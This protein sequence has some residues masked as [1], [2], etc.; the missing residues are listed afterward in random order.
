MNSFQFGNPQFIPVLAIIPFLIIL[1]LIALYLRKKTIVKFGNYNIIKTLMPNYSKLRLNIKFIVL[2]LSL[3][4][5]IIAIC[6]PQFGSKLEESKRS[7]VEIVLALDVS[8][9]MLAEDIKPNRIESAKR[10]ISRMIDGLT[11]DKIAIIV[12]AGDAYTQL[13]MT[14]DFGAAKMFLNTINTGFVEKQGTAIGKAIELAMHSFTPGVDAGKTIIVITDG[15]N[16]DDKPLPSVQKATERGIVVHTIGIGSLQGAPIPVYNNY[17]QKDFRKDRQGNVVI[18][19]LDE[20]IL[21]DIAFQ[22]N[23]VYIRATNTNFGLNTIFEKI[24]EMDKAEL[25]A[26]VYTEYDEQFQYFIAIS[27]FLLLLEYIILERKNK[28]TRNIKLFE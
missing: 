24:K 6:R 12:F 19:K 16:H 21:Q 27:L 2:L 23:G 9:S 15:E 17:R 20:K 26:V 3:S 25:D 13:P 4:A 18:T 28:F 10:S 7:G 11:D 5:L 14:S 1:Y 8:N 22:G